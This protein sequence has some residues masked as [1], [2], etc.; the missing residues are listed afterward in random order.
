[1]L[2]VRCADRRATSST[3]FLS[4]NESRESRVESRESLFFSLASLFSL[5]LL[6]VLFTPAIDADTRVALDLA[7]GI[8]IPIAPD[9]VST[10]WKEGEAIEIRLRHPVSPGITFLLLTG[11]YRFFLQQDRNYGGLN[12]TNLKNIQR[13]EG[14]I[15]EVQSLGGGLLI[16]PRLERRADYYVLLSISWDRITQHSVTF[17]T[18]EFR[19]IVKPPLPSSHLGVVFGAGF[20]VRQWRII[21]PFVEVVDHVVNI[22]PPGSDEGALQFP[23]IKVGI[24]TRIK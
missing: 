19:Q 20:I 3:G 14:G 5:L 11:R 24:T 4:N 12:V 10:G 23:T 6:F 16:A 13:T 7:G 1:M 21:S 17:L 22:A 8:G 9:R 18:P 15:L 2:N